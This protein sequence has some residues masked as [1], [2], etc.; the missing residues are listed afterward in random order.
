MLPG[1]DIALIA[2]RIELGGGEA[3][4]D[5]ATAALS[6]PQPTYPITCTQG[7]VMMHV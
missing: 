2:A 7:G 6:I 5:P 4:T 3:K 1:L